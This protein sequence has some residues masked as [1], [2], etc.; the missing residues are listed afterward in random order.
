M[1]VPMVNWIVPSSSYK[2][3]DRSWDN[4]VYFTI[5][6]CTACVLCGIS[7]CF[8]LTPTWVGW[9]Q[10]YPCHYRV[11]LADGMNG[12]FCSTSSCNSYSSTNSNCFVRWRYH[13]LKIYDSDVNPALWPSLLV[14]ECT[15]NSRTELS[16]QYVYYSNG[17]NGQC[18][19]R[20][21]MNDFNGS[22]IGHFSVRNNVGIAW[23]FVLGSLFGIVG[24][25]FWVPSC[26]HFASL[27]CC[28][29][30]W[31]MHLFKRCFKHCFGRCHCRRKKSVTYGQ[32]QQ[33]QQQMD[34]KPNIY[35][36]T[37]MHSDESPQPLPSPYVTSVLLPYEKQPIVSSSTTV[38]NKS[39]LS[40]QQQQ[41]NNYYNNN[42][43]PLASLRNAPNQTE[44]G[45]PAVLVQPIVPPPPPP[46]TTTT[47]SILPV[48]TFIPSSPNIS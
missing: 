19:P 6:F 22:V 46:T 16:G 28:V 21:T 44:I 48:V 45:Y 30:V 5:F 23:L 8:Y 15:R 25:V 27:V 11:D 47:T 32:Q 31:I 29:W 36:K 39:V 4:F 12:G 14:E 13:I 20:Q 3:Y 34:S 41:H 2:N 38:S 40:N 37:S 17:P 35:G 43:S 42:M 9:W 18:S 7:V 24:L 26:I 10:A 1:G 33:Q